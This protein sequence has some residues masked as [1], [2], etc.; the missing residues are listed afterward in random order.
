MH[1]CVL[2]RACICTYV[3]NR[4]IID[5]KMFT[6]LEIF[7]LFDV[8]VVAIFGIVCLWFLLGRTTDVWHH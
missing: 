1:A 2:M 3:E 4:K 8:S 5:V 6:P 7:Q